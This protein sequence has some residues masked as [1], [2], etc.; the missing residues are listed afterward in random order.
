MVFRYAK[1]SLFRQ[2][3]YKGG[4]SRFP[5]QLLQRALTPQ[6]PWVS[7][8]RDEFT[9]KPVLA[10][11]LP[12]YLLPRRVRYFKKQITHL[13]SARH[14]APNGLCVPLLRITWNSLSWNLSNRWSNASHR[15]SGF[16]QFAL[17]CSFVQHAQRYRIRVQSQFH[18]SRLL[19]VQ[20]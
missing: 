6:F 15:R 20:S 2:A 14:R 10:F 19:Y 12:T 18:R 9:S 17:Q 16:I 7:S 3:L 13:L 8:C 1:H 5:T 11:R 4:A